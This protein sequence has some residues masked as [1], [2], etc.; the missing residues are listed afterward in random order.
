MIDGLRVAVVVPAFRV[1]RE[2]PDVVKAMPA[3]VDLVIVVDDCSPDDIAGALKPIADPR[4]RL[5]RHEVNQGVGGA[6]VTGMLTAIEEGADVVVKCDGDGQMDPADIPRLIAPIA[7]GAAEHVKGSRYHH[8]R[9]LAAMPR[10]RLIGNIGLTFLTKLC[11]GYWN[12]LDPV[13][14]FFA[15]RTDTLA[16]LPLDQLA[17]RY[18]FETDLLIRLNIVEARV[19]DMPQPARYAGEPSSLSIRRAL[20]EFPWQLLRGLVRRVFWRYLFYDVSPVAVFGITGALLAAF[21]GCFG[22]WQWIVHAMQHVPTPLGT[23]MLAAL[24]LLFGGQLLFQAVILDIANT[25]RASVRTSALIPRLRSA[26]G[27]A[28][29]AAAE[30]SSFAPHSEREA[31]AP[32]SSA[33]PNASSSER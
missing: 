33:R 14:G 5:V 7:S 22:A 11:S 24:P 30:S 3:A 16:R 31:S 1:A 32:P 26:R 28:E 2:V 4:L 8:A 23:I 18:F 29:L 6:T 21:G 19:A 25:P 27:C 15:T 17:R 9:E 12:V 10:G 13:N 20:F